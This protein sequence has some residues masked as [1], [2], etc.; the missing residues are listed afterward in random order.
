MNF[1]DFRKTLDSI[2]RETMFEILRKYGVPSEFVD[3]ISVLYTNSTARVTTE[4]GVSDSFQV[5][6]GVLQGDTLAPYLFVKVLDYALRTSITDSLGFT[7]D[8]PRGQRQPGATLQILSS[9][10][11]LHYCLM[12]SATHKNY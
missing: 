8:Q 2:K 7:I 9:Q 5:A 4:D 1:I 3:A 6:T 12:T 10:T 11:I